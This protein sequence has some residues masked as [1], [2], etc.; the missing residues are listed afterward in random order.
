M[1]AIRWIKLALHVLIIIVI[2]GKM[3]RLRGSITRLYRNL[4]QGLILNRHR[5]LAVSAI[6]IQLIQGPIVHCAMEVWDIR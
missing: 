1:A 3:E 4:I 2:T 5:L 6:A